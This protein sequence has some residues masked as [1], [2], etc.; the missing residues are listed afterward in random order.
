M[1][2]VDS[3]TPG[4]ARR[5]AAVVGWPVAKAASA[6]R[7]DQADGMTVTLGFDE[8]RDHAAG[9]APEIGSRVQHTES[10]GP[11]HP[12]TVAMPMPAPCTARRSRA[13]A[14]REA[15]P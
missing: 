14:P 6:G 1:K 2:Q 5:D 9:S 7:G 11:G 15:K 12:T 13:P 8:L 3:T 10:S 4:T